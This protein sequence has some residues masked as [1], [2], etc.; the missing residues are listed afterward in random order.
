MKVF[1]PWE[2]IPP[3]PLILIVRW[4]KNSTEKRGMNLE[5]PEQAHYLMV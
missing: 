4:S 5:M 1:I 2:E 3:Y